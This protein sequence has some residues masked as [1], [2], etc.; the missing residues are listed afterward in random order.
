MRPHYYSM[1]PPPQALLHQLLSPNADLPSSAAAFGGDIDTIGDPD[2]IGGG[3]GAGSSAVMQ[4]LVMMTDLEAPEP[5]LS[6]VLSPRGGAEERRVMR[7]MAVGDVS[8]ESLLAAVKGGTGSGTATMVSESGDVLF[9][10][11]ALYPL[12]M[13]RYEQYTARVGG[14]G[15]AAP[16]GGGGGGATEL[17]ASA[18]KSALRY[19]QQYNS[20]VMLRGALAAVAEAWAQAVEVAFTRQYDQLAAA[21]Q[22]RSPTSFRNG[23]PE[24]LYEVLSATLEALRRSLSR[25]GIAGSGAGGAAEAMVLQYAGVARMLLSKLQEQVRG[26]GLCRDR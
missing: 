4:L 13:A 2:G 3:F 21:L 7:E 16:G 10:V 12:L 17:A 22:L 9:D 20:Y 25:V 8:V 14:G 23:P 5:Q 6:D 24:A 11:A 1:I 18:V 19:A 26:R 15:A